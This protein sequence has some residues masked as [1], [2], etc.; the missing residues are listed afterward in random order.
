MTL[1]NYSMIL[2]LIL[3]RLATMTSP[4]GAQNSERK[5]RVFKPWEVYLGPVILFGGDFKFSVAAEGGLSRSGVLLPTGVT[6]SLNEME[7]TIRE[8]RTTTR[9]LNVLDRLSTQDGH[10]LGFFFGIT[11]RFE[12][13]P[14]IEVGVLG[15]FQLL[16]IDESARI[17][18]FS[19]V[20]ESQV[21]QINE[22]TEES[23]A[24]MESATY[25]DFFEMSLKGLEY[26][27]RLG[28][29][30]R[31][32]MT[33][34]SSQT[35]FYVSVAGGAELL[36]ADVKLTSNSTFTSVVTRTEDDE[37]P[38]D[39]PP[40]RESRMDSDESTK[41]LAG[42]FIN[43]AFGYEFETRASIRAF[44]GLSSPRDYRLTAG[45]AV[46]KRNT[47]IWRVGLVASLSF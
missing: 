10:E 15:E 14:R 33:D 3:V 30:L 21:N 47:P 39:E 36:L 5:D 29:A 38:R 43:A 22:D 12:L 6:T 32:R 8:E 34:G 35:G 18:P 19:G 1:K 27:F 23:R 9:Q 11:R 31:Y 7:Q 24:F 13:T 42:G 37:P 16:R 28:P 40:R 26:T 2:L 46:V 4:V 20:D 45:D 41:L 25:N 44:A 17:F